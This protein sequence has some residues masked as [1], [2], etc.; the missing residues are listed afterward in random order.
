[1]ESPRLWW[2]AA[3]G[4]TL[5]GARACGGFSALDGPVKP[6]SCTVT[7]LPRRRSPETVHLIR[8]CPL[9][10]RFFISEDRR[11]PYD[12]GSFRD[13]Y[14]QNRQSVEWAARAVPGSQMLLRPKSQV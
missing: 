9:F 2:S 13:V 6:R 11:F 5:S 12:V 3:Q 10:G 1:M 4:K 14:W 7:L 8:T